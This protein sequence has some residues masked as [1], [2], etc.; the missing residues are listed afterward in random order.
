MPH[1][2]LLLSIASVLLAASLPG[3]QPPSQEL[4]SQE[5]ACQQP[6][7]E[8]AAPPRLLD[9][10][11]APARAAAAG[12]LA[13]AIVDAPDVATLVALAARAKTTLPLGSAAR[14]RLND[15]LMAANRSLAGGDGALRR[16]RS[17]LADVVTTLRFR[18]LEQA[19]LPEGFPG[20]A[21]VD[22]VELRHYPAYAMAR[23]SMRRGSMGA[24]WPL[25]RHIEENNIPMTT[26]VQM[27]YAAADERRP[28]RMA[29]LYAR[30]SVEPA[31]VAEGIEVVRVDAA[32][33]LSIGAIG[34]DRAARVAALADSLRDWLATQQQWTA[35]GP[36]R[37]MG[38]NSP[39]VSRD[40]RYFEVQ[41]PIARP[42]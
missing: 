16:L 29:F 38:Y 4:P 32:T 19:E 2:R 10:A 36:I 20:F 23:T 42:Q 24:F 7:A 12:A 26:P 39:M 25:F 11:D 41:L 22:E 6:V 34:D 35:A 8:A 30:P 15:A 28:V 3:Q 40:E 31:T 21:A 13:D 27:D 33:V 14:A 18:P 5:P 37:V 17:D 1:R 9:P